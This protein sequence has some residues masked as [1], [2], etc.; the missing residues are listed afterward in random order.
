MRQV[1]ITISK[2]IIHEVLFF[3]NP[4]MAIRALAACVKHMNVEYGDAALYDENGL[5]ANAKH[6]LDEHDAYCENEDLIAE[7]SSEKTQSVFIIGNPEHRLGFM[8]VSPDDPLGY[9]DPAAALSDLGQMRQDYGSHLKLYRAVP[10]DG[11]VSTRS[12]LN[13]Y[14]HASGIDEV[15]YEQVEDYLF[16]QKGLNKYSRQ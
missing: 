1:L 4:G 7:V 3:D 2:G 5:V 16:D 10:V 15:D 12:A 6:F 11:P 9:E 14:T 13:K 8:V